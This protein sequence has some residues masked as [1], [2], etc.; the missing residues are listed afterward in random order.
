[1]HRFIWI[2]V[3]SLSSTLALGAGCAATGGNDTSSASTSSNDGGA[4]HGGQGG[5]GASLT[6][7]CEPGCGD[8]E[9]CLDGACCAVDLACAGICCG[10]GSFCSFGSCVTPGDD[11]T[12][13]D[14]CAPDEY[15]ETA[16]GQTNP[17]QP[18]CISTATGKCLP[19]PP[20][21]PDGV[22]PDPSQGELTCLATCE[23]EPADTAFEV[24]LAYAWGG[25]QGE[26]AE[27]FPHDVRN[28]PIVVQ[29]DDDDCDGKVSSLD[30]PEIVFTTSPFD[31]AAVKV[32]DVK[33]ISIVGG[34]VV[35]KWT[36]PNAG[37]PHRYLAAG[38][39]DGQPGNEVIVC[40][41]DNQTVAYRVDPLDGSATPTVLWVSDELCAMPSI[42]DL[43]QDGI[44]EIITRAAILSGAD[45]S[46][47]AKYSQTQGP[48]S[49]IAFPIVGDVNGDGLLE[50]VSHNR[51]FD[52]LGMEIA[53]AP[54]TGRYPAMADFDADGTPE[55]V[56][57]DFDNHLVHVWRYDAAAP[58]G[59][60]MV[61]E[62]ID[63]NTL[64]STTNC[65]P[66]SNGATKGGGPPTIADVDGDGTPDLAVAGGTGYVVM[67]G[68]KLMD[69]AVPNSGVF[70]WATPTIDC[71]SA[72][73][74]SSVFDFNGDGKAEVLYG[75]EQYF[76]I[77]DGQTEAVLFETCNT[78]GTILELPVV[79]DVDNDG[80]ADVVVASNARYF[81]CEGTKQSGIRIFSSKNGN[82]VRTR[83]VWNQHAYHVT[84][85]GED[86]SIPL[87]EA[88]NHLEPGLN[89]FRQ[90]KQP[91]GEFAA[92]DVAVT[93]RGRCGSP[94]VMAATVYNLGQAPLP[95][96][97]DVTLYQ[98]MAPS[99]MAIGT[100]S[101]TTLLLPAQSERL[102]FD[103]A[104]APDVESGAEPAHAVVAPPSGVT[105]CR[106]DNNASAVAVM[107]CGPK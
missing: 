94:R 23:V 19:A 46:T 58:N 34:Q 90:N 76:R 102:E 88:A 11:C 47:V 100:L 4:G 99:G 78:N 49:G 86:G 97:V 42:A 50:I 29:L 54:I 32:G 105:E 82:W 17:P 84:N 81:T 41:P 92:P 101:T 59:V 75:D 39:I 31:G 67:D 53:E 16:L 80:Q 68:T 10:G 85:V 45:G 63:L 25:Y 72:Q 44:A 79:A 2:A 77:Y 95:A 14:D 91:G 106:P 87:V 21:C 38:N 33:A 93:L 83:R 12:N 7:A 56:T 71:S 20:T 22:V 27:P 89:N 24:E 37:H 62:G 6:N 9:V 60:E 15:C 74:G 26:T 8:E 5:E 96:G 103:L 18:G 70:L 51:V 57:I 35:E 43:D 48:I 40:S 30:I 55:I 1:M 104:S 28:A 36:L 52:G 73:T 64:L 66:T 65:S 13:A 3:A 107:E 69:P 61:R 98:G